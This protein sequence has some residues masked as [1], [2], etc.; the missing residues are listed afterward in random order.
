MGRGP[1][2]PTREHTNPHLGLFAAIAALYSH[3]Y[4]INFTAGGSGAD[5]GR[6]GTVALYIDVDVCIGCGACEYGC[7]TGAIGKT[8]TQLGVFVI[9]THKCN[10]CGVCPTV[11]PVDCIFQEPESIICH[12][13]GCPVAPT[14]RGGYAGWQCSEL[15]NFCDQCGNVLWSAPGSDEWVCVR[16]DLGQPQRWCPKV[17]SLAK[18]R[19]GQ[20]LPKGQ[21]VVYRLEPVAE[22]GDPDVLV[23]SV[24]RR[25]T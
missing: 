24:P 8:D 19:T 9:E 13:R 23:G 16:C 5:H 21:P 17:A 14:A 1:E 22:P 25:N 7:P 2:L 10:D 15:T 3:P 12:E 6:G 18:G 11:C 4:R 20:R